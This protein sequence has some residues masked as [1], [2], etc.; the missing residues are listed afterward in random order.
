MNGKK[1][2]RNDLD[3]MKPV[4]KEIAHELKISR[5]YFQLFAQ[6]FLFTR[7][8]FEELMQSEMQNSTMNIA[9]LAENLNSYFESMSQNFHERNDYLLKNISYNVPFTKNAN[10]PSPLVNKINLGDEFH[11]H[12]LDFIEVI[13]S[14]I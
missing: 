3:G 5:D 8:Q 4:I 12:N 10:F 13:D 11:P 9:E 2:D 14:L 6:L 1:R 7:G